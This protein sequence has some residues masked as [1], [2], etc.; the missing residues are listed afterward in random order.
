MYKLSATGTNVALNA[1]GLAAA[2]AYSGGGYALSANDAGDSLGHLI[3]ITG[4]AATDHS[5]KT[6]TVTGT[7]SDDQPIAEGIAGPNG[8][9]AVSTTKYFKTVTSVTVSSTTGADTFDIG[10][11]AAAVSA[12]ILPL[13]KSVRMN[14]QF[15]I[16]FGCVV[17]TGTPTFS[18]Q[19]TYDN[20]AWFNHSVVA[21][22]NANADGVYTSPVLAMRIIWSAAGQVTLTGWQAGD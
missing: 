17:G 21:A 7:N 8:A 2:V 10:W 16:G 4:K 5:G 18:V 9:V 20:V 3:T 13:N 11:T 19:H 15:N 6:F 1:S 22:K 14:S 12:T